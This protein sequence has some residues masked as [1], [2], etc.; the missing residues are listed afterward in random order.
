MCNFSLQ[1]PDSRVQKQVKK[2]WLTQL[3]KTVIVSSYVYKAKYCR[4]YVNM[5]YDGSYATRDLLVFPTEEI[6]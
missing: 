5:L 4:S 3:C 6:F 2:A 1:E